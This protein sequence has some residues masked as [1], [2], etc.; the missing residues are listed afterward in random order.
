MLEMENIPARKPLKEY[1]YGGASWVNIVL[2]LVFIYS[3]SKGTE[4][5]MLVF[6]L[7]VAIKI[8]LLYQRPGTAEGLYD[9][10]LEQD[11]VYLKKRAVEIMGLIEEEF[12]LIEPIVLNGYATIEVVSIATEL[13]AEK[14][15]I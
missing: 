9:S 13:T 8:I 5:A 10:I 7:C 6:A 14:K 11:I 3:L 4:V 15:R 1:F 2:V 12:S